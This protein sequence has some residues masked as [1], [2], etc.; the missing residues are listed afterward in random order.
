[1]KPVNQEQVTHRSGPTK[2]D[3][4]K[5]KT[6]RHKSKG[7][8]DVLKKGRTAQHAAKSKANHQ[9]GRIERRNQARLHR[10]IK[11]DNVINE[12]R[13]SLSLPHLVAVIPLSNNI[14]TN[15]KLIEIVNTLQNSDVK[16]TTAH[17]PEGYSHLWIDQLK[18]AFTFVRPDC[19]SI[20]GL[21]DTLK[22][23]DTIL[24]IVSA[25]NGLDQDV[26]LLMTCILAQ[27]LPSTVVAITDLDKIPLKKQNDVKQCIQKSIETWLPDEK[28]SK[29]DNS[30]DILNIL[31][32]INSQKKRSITFRDKRAHLLAEE[33]S[34]LPGID[35]NFGTMK[36]SGFLRG[37]S[38]SVNSLIHIPG[39][40]DFQMKQIDLASNDFVKSFTG[41]SIQPTVL[42]TADPKVQE[43]LISEN[44]PDPMDAEQ[45]WP[46]EE[47]IQDVENK[48]KSKRMI[49]RVPQ[50]MS[51]YQSAWIPDE[52]SDDDDM[53]SDLSEN[54]DNFFSI[55]DDYSDTEMKSILDDEMD[56]M[57]VTTVASEA[58]IESDKY[59]LQ[60]D[61]KEE[62]KLLTKLKEAKADQ[63]FPDEVDT[64][65]DLP[66]RV[67]FEKYRGL[68]SFRT[69]PWDVKENLP[70]D[71]GRIFQF[72][73]FDRTRKR[74]FKNLGNQNG[75]LP[76]WY[77]TI[78]IENV[79]ATMFHSR[80]GR[81][82]VVIFG[83]LP[84][85]QKM[86]VINVIL[87]RP[88]SVE[89]EEP[90]KSK[91]SLI[92]Q[93]GFRRFTAEPIFSQ[94]TNG[95]KF[96]YERFFHQDNIVVATM[97]APIIFP[98]CSV[99]AL[100]PCK[101]GSYQVIGNGSILSINPNRLIIKRTV[102]SGHP[103]KVHKRSAVVRFMF[104]N[105][106]DIEWFKPVELRTK[107]GR[108]G[109]I[110]EPLGTH[111]HMKC[112][113]D[114]QVKSQDIVCMNLYKRV[115]P[116]WTYDNFYNVEK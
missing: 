68:Q 111:G 14:F 60:F 102:L 35:D 29:F 12:K 41:K 40:G 88:T 107:Y 98:P 7:T 104:F 3:N 8:L 83:L 76:D 108:R 97:F 113:F 48:L 75:A 9:L 28:I 90:I 96:K 81:N 85:E 65:F 71:Y 23:V 69:S 15:E 116:K 54:S 21:L 58:P 36:V 70:S 94:H 105:R 16:L 31:R 59:D 34:F 44:I 95:N 99:I 87:K 66:A 27:G 32:R 115:F 17:A 46:T 114:G 10:K 49:K 109:H 63:M 42:E 13:R 33:L 1:M 38:L 82:P 86:S 84:H 43:S 19:S 91:T 39:W 26:D 92:F 93:C 47:E 24:F 74:V 5:H 73:N 18:Q 30:T 106:E 78:Y 77:I 101:D 100:K 62:E 25:E 56:T 52:E 45:T 57:S 6:G 79:P 103:F 53:N 61:K 80:D 64:P 51:V 112:G 67:R 20:F 2:Q 89:F 50:G 72:E 11:T 55:K 4:K 37:Q 110:K 22:V